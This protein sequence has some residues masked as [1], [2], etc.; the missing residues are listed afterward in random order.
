MLR[1]SLVSLSALAII[2]SSAC[3][4]S[5]E[6]Q[7]VSDSA[8]EPRPI[9]VT[10]DAYIE[11]FNTGDRDV[12]RQFIVE[13]FDDEGQV[14]EADI[15]S[16]S[17]GMLE[18]YRR[19]GPVEVNSI[20]LDRDNI[21]EAWVTGELT[22]GQSLILVQIGSDGTMSGN[23]DTSGVRA[24][25]AADRLDVVTPDTLSAALDPY[26]EALVDGDHYSGGA[27]IV[28]GDE[29][30]YSFHGGAK[31]RRTGE[32]INADTLFD[33]ASVGKMITATVILSLVE[34]GTV[35]LEDPIGQ[36]IPDYPE[37]WASG[38]TIEHLLTHTSGIELDN[39]ATFMSELAEATSIREMVDLQVE[40]V[41]RV[42]ALN[43]FN[44]GEQ[45]NYTNEGYVL[46]GGIAEAASGDS[47]ETLME[48]RVFEPAG[49]TR[50]VPTSQLEGQT[51]VAIPHSLTRN[52]RESTYYE[53]VSPL[54]DT[55]TGQDWLN[56]G[57]AIP[58][59]PVYSTGADL[60]AFMTALVGGELLSPDMVEAMVSPIALRADD[61]IFGL[62]EHQGLGVKIVHEYGVESF[63][64]DG[65]VPGFRT[66]LYYYPDNDMTILT[67]SNSEGAY[68]PAH[69]HMEDLTAIRRE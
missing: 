60:I 8:S 53:E 9:E 69:Q 29:V 24:R 37:P 21:R 12:Y 18:A 43:T 38:V 30:I 26:F 1:S 14:A 54:V 57:V 17:G 36:W 39:D 22:R 45:F 50:T 6:T 63:G 65:G 16:F 32:I 5:V 13:W 23:G 7:E 51:N 28:I 41:V 3:G 59:S 25:R 68:A 64:H 62:L 4:Q 15:E 20:E 19:L 11:A 56:N 31:D 66:K 40:H 48:D 61:D 44:P 67:W 2:S 55:E 46:L 34:D 35:S 52:R 42:L 47:F 27:W 33:P 58:A 10:Y 49:M